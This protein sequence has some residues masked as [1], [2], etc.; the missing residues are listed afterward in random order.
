M[1]VAFRQSGMAGCITAMT[2]FLKATCHRRGYGKPNIHPMQPARPLRI[3]RKVRLKEAENAPAQQATTKPGLRIPET[4]MRRA[5]ALLLAILL[6]ACGSESSESPQ[7]KGDDPGAKAG[8]SRS[9]KPTAESGQVAKNENGLGTPNKDRIATLGLLNK[10][11]NLTKDL[12]MKTGESR[13]VGNIIVKLDSCER[14]A[15]WETAE[16]EGAF[17]QIFIHE[18]PAPKQDVVWRKVFSGWLF[19][20]APAINVLEHP[21]YDVWVKKCAMNF[22]GD[23]P[24]PAAS[25]SSSNARKPS[26]NASGASSPSE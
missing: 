20:N 9:A 5:S 4:T 2:A 13:R 19:K 6:A 11:N 21:V 16:E 7:A 14:T 12:V 18:R 10:R 22:P 15:P 17:V 26:G 3:A 24:R 1:P 8:S 25:A 23:E